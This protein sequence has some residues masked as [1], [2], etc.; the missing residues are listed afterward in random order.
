[1]AAFNMSF[2]QFCAAISMEPD[3][4]A[5]VKYEQFKQIGRAMMRFDDATLAALARDYSSN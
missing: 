2:D 4:Y 5:E 1:M 3:G